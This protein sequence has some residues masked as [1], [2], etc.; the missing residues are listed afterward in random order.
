MSAIVSFG[1]CNVMLME[2]GLAPFAGVGGSAWSSAGWLGGRPLCV[3]FFSNVE[4]CGVFFRRSGEGGACTGG[5]AF[6]R[7]YW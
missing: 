2:G 4:G 7:G 3:W 1:S 5:I 6:A